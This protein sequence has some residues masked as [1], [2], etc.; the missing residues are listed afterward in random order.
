MDMPFADYLSA[1][2]PLD[3]RS[4]NRSVYELL[5]ATLAERQA[6]RCLD[7][8]T[9][10][11]AMLKR[12]LES[13]NV[14]LSLTGLD[15]QA[16]LLAMAEQSI[17]PLLPENNVVELA[18][19]NTTL[20]DFSAKPASFDLITAHGFMDI[21]PLQTS[22]QRFAEWLAP[23][24]LFYAT[25][26]YDGDTAL[27]P[28][29]H[30]EA[31]EK[32]L[33]ARYDESME[34]RRVDGLATGG[35]RSGRRLHAALLAEGFTLLAYGSSDW[36]ITP[37]NGAYRDADGLCLHALLGFIRAEGEAVQFNADALKQWHATRLAQIETA[38]LG[39]IIHQLDVLA[40]KPGLTARQ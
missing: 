38:Q 33:L 5:I 15:Q 26:N 28:I 39:L 10:T 4:L 29:Y 19:I 30:D 31:F 27:F 20:A 11:G 3:E 18:L 17:K 13:V 14:P 40:A 35:S 8:G 36:N 37:V 2:Y 32:R 9:G 22:V 1:K 25:L 34:Q 6:V 23:G 21:V 16:D 12:L 7:V 24:G